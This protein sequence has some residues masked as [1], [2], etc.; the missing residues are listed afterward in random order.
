M[1]K[2]LSFLICLLALAVTRCDTQIGVFRVARAEDLLIDVLEEGYTDIPWNEDGTVAEPGEADKAS[3]ADELDE[4]G[5]ETSQGYQPL[6]NDPKLYEA[7]KESEVW[8]DESEDGEN[9][10]LQRVQLID[11]DFYDNNIVSRWTGKWLAGDTIWV[12]AMGRRDI[13][14]NQGLGYTLAAR[15]CAVL[16]YHYYQ[17]QTKVRF[18]VFDPTK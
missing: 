13:P 2:L 18:G 7:L 16:N 11:G 6:A 14:V 15:S 1:S 9:E 8:G 17:N 3:V 10:S 5:Q 4:V 12:I